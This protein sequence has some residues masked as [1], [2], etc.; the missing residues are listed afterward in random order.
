[1]KPGTVPFFIFL[2]SV[3]VG[4]VG[5]GDFFTPFFFQKSRVKWSYVS[6]TNFMYD[7]EEPMYDDDGGGGGCLGSLVGIAILMW[8]F[9]ALKV[10][11][12]ILLIVAV[13]A[14]L[15]W[16]FRAAERSGQRDAEIAAQQQAERKAEQE[17]R[18]QLRKAEEARLAHAKREAELAPLTEYLNAQK[19]P[20]I[21]EKLAAANAILRK[22]SEETAE[23][24]WTRIV[25]F[26]EKYLPLMTEPIRA[27]DHGDAD[28]DETIR[29]FTETVKAFSR[30][31]YDVDEVVDINNTLIRQLAMQ[32]GLIDP[33][34][35]QM[36][37]E[38]AEPAP[39]AVQ[40]G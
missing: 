38:T 16:L 35:D 36:V 2:K 23:A 28:I 13:I 29:T 26:Y 34:R 31:L 4:T 3:P 6:L 30:N 22:L 14:L 33:L 15:V 39:S 1:M 10:V 20:E 9:E 12:V 19:S 37:Q 25:N 24:K 27:T 7:S 40:R 18:E 32:D 11:G 21:K 8:M 5:D 17:R